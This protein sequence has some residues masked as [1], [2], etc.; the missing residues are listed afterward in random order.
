MDIYTA[1]LRIGNK[2]NAK[3]EIIICI[4]LKYRCLKIYMI[5]DNWITSGL[6][7]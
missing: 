1:R 3:K 6:T 5:V 2:K 7:L 4:N